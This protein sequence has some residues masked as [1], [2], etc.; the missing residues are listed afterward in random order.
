MWINDNTGFWCIDELLQ[1]PH[2]IATIH[3][4]HIITFPSHDGLIRFGT[5]KKKLQAKGLTSERDVVANNGIVI[6]IDNL[7]LPH[8]YNAEVYP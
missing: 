3:G 2:R 1:R 6:A 7:L 4:Q 8:K 5:T